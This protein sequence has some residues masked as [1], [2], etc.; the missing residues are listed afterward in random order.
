[1][2][3]LK[4]VEI[5]DC[6][7][8]AFQQKSF[9]LGVRSGAKELC[10]FFPDCK[11]ETFAAKRELYY[12]SSQLAVSSSSSTNSPYMIIAMTFNEFE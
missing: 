5:G 4:V 8:R 10:W 6:L 11:N 7:S 9:V 2:E 3:I 12:E 1:M